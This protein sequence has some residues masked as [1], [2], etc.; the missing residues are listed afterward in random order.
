M[1]A[2]L[3]LSTGDRLPRVAGVEERGEVCIWGLPTEGYYST[4]AMPKLKHI[5][6]RSAR[7]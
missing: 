2:H 4:Y 6:D 1:H 7:M 3:T 5:N